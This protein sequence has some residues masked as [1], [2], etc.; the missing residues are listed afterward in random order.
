MKGPLNPELKVGDVIVLLHMEK[1]T[2]VPP[3]TIGVVEKISRDPFE[4]PDEKIISVKWE[5]GSALG[6]ITSTDA[7]KKVKSEE[8]IQE[9]RDSTWDFMTQN[10]DIFENFD[11]RWLEQFLYKVRDS[12]IVNMYGA[13]PLLYAGSEHIDR[14]FGEGKEDDENF[15]AVLEDAD[16]SKNKIIQ[17]VIKFMEKNNKD[18]DNLDQVNR[19][20]QNFSQKILGLYIALSNM[21]NRN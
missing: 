18:L 20:A 7:W 3:G 10:V 1:E 9:S 6:L 12:G 19:Y 11:W 15:Q 2:A 14:Y 8:N 13:A 21:G 5:N 17:G 4:S 16:E